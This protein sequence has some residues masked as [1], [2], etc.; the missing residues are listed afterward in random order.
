MAKPRGERGSWFAEWKG[1]KLPCVH[2]CW[3]RGIWPHHCDPGVSDK[4]QWEPFIN[5]LKEGRAILTEDELDKEGVPINRN[6]Y[7]AL[8]RIE[9][10]TLRGNELHFDFT[11]RL[12]DFR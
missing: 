7:V 8:Y 11:E 12:A 9:N 6:G 4:P 10:V 3:T 2:R 5:A 1:E